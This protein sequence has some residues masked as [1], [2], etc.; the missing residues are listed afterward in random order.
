MR[1][2]T[3]SNLATTEL[4][5]VVRA[6]RRRWRLRRVLR[7]G[8]WF[9]L[10]VGAV[11]LAA[12]AVMDA[13]RFAEPVVTGVRAASYT[14]L[15]VALCAFVG[16]PLLRRV[17]DG[18]IA[19]YAEEQMP[20]LGMALATAV[21]VAAADEERPGN[22]LRDGLLHRAVAVGRAH[23]SAMERHALRRALWVFGATL[24]A[25]A[26]LLTL[27]PGPLGVGMGL[28]MA[29]FADRAAATPYAVAIQP[30]DARIPRG[31]DQLIAARV[32]GFQPETV[33]LF[34][35]TA[36]DGDWRSADMN[37]ATE[38]GGFERF[39]FNVEASTEYYVVADELRSPVYHLEVVDL[40][41]VARIDLTYHYPAY[42]GRAPHTV[43]DGG[44]V[45]ALRGSRVELTITPSRDVVE[46]TLVVDD[47]RSI[48]LRLNSDS[49]LAGALEIERDGRYRIALRAAQDLAG[50]S[51][52]YMIEVVAD[53]PPIAR[54]VSPGRDARVT[55]IEEPVIEVTSSD[56]VAVSKLELVY[57]VNG[58]AEQSVVL[59]DGAPATQQIDAAHTFYLEHLDLVPGDLIAFYARARD[60]NADPATTDL[61]FLEVRPFERVFRQS[62]GAGAGGAGG[63]GEQD[64]GPLSAQ[65][66]QL[67]IATF[68][69]VRERNEYPEDRLVE[70]VETLA[71]AQAR[72]HDRVAA[73]MRR[74]GTRPIMQMHE[75]LQRMAEELPE[76]ADAMRA[77]QALLEEHQPDAALAPARRALL[78]LQRAEA[79]FRETEV[80][81]G[82]QSGS[83]AGATDSEDLAELFRLE[84]DKLRN[85]YESVQRGQQQ[86]PETDLDDV[87]ERL[88]ELARRQQREVERMRRRAA[89]SGGGGGSDSQRA[90]LEEVEELA[91]RLERLSREQQRPELA[92][93]REQLQQAAAAMRR[94]AEASATGGGQA[95][96]QAAADHL[97]EARRAAEAQRREQLRAGVEDVRERAR[98]LA[99]EQREAEKALRALPDD[100]ERG[101]VSPLQQ[102][103]QAMADETR[104][105]EDELRRL[106]REARERQPEV[107]RELRDAARGLRDDRLAELNERAAR[108]LDS[109]EREALLQLEARIAEGVA[110]LQEELADADAAFDAAS[111]EEQLAEGLERLRRLAQGLEALREDT[112]RRTTQ[113]SAAPDATPGQQAQAAAADGQQAQAGQQDSG[114][115]P[116][117]SQSASGN[118]PAQGQQDSGGQP[119]ASQSASG[120]EPARG[121]PGR[122]GRSGS[123]AGG[124]NGDGFDTS[125]RARI[126]ES[127]AAGRRTLEALRDALP[128]AEH[129]A[130]DIGR[131]I[132]E[133]RA[134][135]QAIAEQ[136]PE[137]ALARQARLIAAL[138]A[139]EFALRQRLEQPA[140]PPTVVEG[141]DTVAPEFRPLVED[142]FRELAR[143]RAAA[144]SKAD[145][146][147]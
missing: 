90:R 61:Y 84:M 130:E 94:A 37:S 89:Q 26:L 140:T 108:A 15:V 75:G 3:S 14:I 43:E 73:I 17:S 27:V 7:G 22:G 10:A 8:T 146:R 111:D 105:I 126:G 98:R 86:M 56:D 42:T 25:V 107:E 38:A 31:T 124:G 46:G 1:N 135:E 115:Q 131:L 50:T 101:D 72:I 106:A 143:T 52:D 24:V 69:V 68:N 55:S 9:L 60:G 13:W 2:A 127:W 77:A 119:G 109:A 35:R 93:T 4:A 142:Y 47:T 5:A 32:D 20:A 71:Q 67:V 136:G 81:Q 40:P 132:A 147:G 85:R 41:R 74:L 66:R 122:A 59:D 83:G 141:G 125:Y 12:A 36:P 92:A 58:G 103:K 6:V 49:T 128:N 87:L 44:D 51:R 99:A 88:R 96:A 110:R 23:V 79:A 39:L 138:K 117:A 145:E 48:P 95:Q 120:N 118:E 34:R 11:V 21:D 70:T 63:G 54:I 19:L 76:A 57:A 139:T 129:H 91:R 104:R 28:L 133:M 116:G 82:S 30:G 16:V 123:F 78:H 112:V 33:R 65:Q 45:T 29:P 80:A 114:G 62:Q 144:A 121:Q 100:G 102:R 137:I 134:I 53:R 113:G 64:E 97:R 18:R